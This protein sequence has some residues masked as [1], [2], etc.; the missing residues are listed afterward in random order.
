MANSTVITVTVAEAPHR[1]GGNLFPEGCDGVSVAIRSSATFVEL[2]LLLQDE[3]SLLRAGNI[4]YHVLPATFTSDSLSDPIVDHTQT[5]SSAGVR[6]GCTIICSLLSDRCPH[7]HSCLRFGCPLSHPSSRPPD[8]PHG[9]SC[10]LTVLRCGRVHPGDWTR[11]L[12]L[13]PCRFGT[14]CSRR[15]TCAYHHGDTF[16]TGV[17][18]DVPLPPS[19]KLFRGASESTPCF[20]ATGSTDI[21]APDT[22]NARPGAATGAELALL[23]HATGSAPPKQRATMHMEAQDAHLKTFSPVS[24]LS[25]MPTCPWTT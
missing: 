22:E 25:T 9:A 4:A 10:T 5:L 19:G 11:A 8:C 13:R 1:R 7:G 12:A 2:T 21:G 15:A 6:S 18:A 17:G 23:L 14:K 24:G 3:H 20:S 16:A